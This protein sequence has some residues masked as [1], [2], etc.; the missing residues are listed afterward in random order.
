MPQIRLS[1]CGKL[2]ALSCHRHVCLEV[3]Q[4][5]TYMEY[6]RQSSINYRVP[7]DGREEEWSVAD[8]HAFVHQD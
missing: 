2:L 3:V 1:A 8:L 4:F 7:G 6:Y 5:F